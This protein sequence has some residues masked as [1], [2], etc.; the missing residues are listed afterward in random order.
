L[1]DPL[2]IIA[3]VVSIATLAFV[4][5]R[6]GIGLILGY[7][8][9]PATL[10]RKREIDSK[11]RAEVRD[12]LKKFLVSLTKKERDEEKELESMNELGMSAY[13]AR[14]ISGELLEDMTR[15]MNSALTC[16]AAT[17][18]S[19][20]ITL[21]IG[22]TSDLSIETN[23]VFLAIFVV[24][25]LFSFYLTTRELKRHYF[26]RERFVRLGE[27]PNL[28]FCRE[29]HEDLENEGLW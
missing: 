29:L 4:V 6:E 23:S 13:F 25:T 10:R 27:N 3:L 18:A 2:A 14:W 24:I 16:L 22:T 12:E 19:L 11:L 5:I 1:Y 20:F 15:Y 9:S 21:Y 8:E 26:L 7:R 28:E 17:L